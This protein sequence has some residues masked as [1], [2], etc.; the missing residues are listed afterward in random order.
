[1]VTRVD[2][3]DAEVFGV[4]A[5]YEEAVAA[6]PAHMGVHEDLDGEEWTG[7]FTGGQG[8][9]QYGQVEIKRFVIGVSRK[10]G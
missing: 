2:Y 9:D 1:M 6:C 10:K 8:W 4:Y 3:E 7:Y 5:S